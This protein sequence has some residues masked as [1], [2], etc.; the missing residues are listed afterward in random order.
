[1]Y[2][3]QCTVM[4]AMQLIILKIFRWYGN[5]LGMLDEIFQ[6]FQIFLWKLVTKGIWKC[7]N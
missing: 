2:F 6:N 5:D 4:N 3:D 1:M 7:G